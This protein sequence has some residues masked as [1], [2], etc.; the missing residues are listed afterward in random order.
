MEILKKILLSVL[1]L[2]TITTQS[3][4]LTSLPDE[5]KR[6]VIS[7]AD[8]IDDARS[9]I[10]SLDQTNK[11]MHTLLRNTH[12]IGLIIFGLSEQLKKPFPYVATMLYQK[13]PG[14][15]KQIIMQWLTQYNTIHT[16]DTA[17]ATIQSLN[18]WFKLDPQ[19]KNKQQLALIE[20]CITLL[21][22][23][24]ITI[25]N[26]NQDDLISGKGIQLLSTLFADGRDQIELAIALLELGVVIDYSFKL[27]QAVT[28]Y[29]KK[30]TGSQRLR[31]KPLMQLLA[32]KGRRLRS[33]GGH[34]HEYS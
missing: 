3:A 8:S 14:W 11:T 26:T 34:R 16:T 29:S 9:L 20:A 17:Q 6:E 5:I 2:I 19:V 22:Q 21:K 18:E 33:L 23:A 32:L 28:W 12:N 7:N 1:S 25:E 27:E 15:L 31:L 4:E 13:S 30:A 24:G 10:T